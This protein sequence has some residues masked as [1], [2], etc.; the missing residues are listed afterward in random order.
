MKDGKQSRV[1]S[2]QVGSSGMPSKP[3]N[4]LRTHY[5]FV[6]VVLVVLDCL[7]PSCSGILLVVHPPA[8]SASLMRLVL[9][10]SR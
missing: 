8:S 3:R 9:A 1:G 7:R 10:L 6:R 4:E 5:A 2:D